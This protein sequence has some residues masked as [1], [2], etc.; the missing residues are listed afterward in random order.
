MGVTELVDLPKWR[1]DEL[2]RAELKLTCLE[3]AG[4]DNWTG[5]EDAMNEFFD[6]LREEEEEEK[7]KDG[8][9]D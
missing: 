5:Y 2:I 8:S 4:V 3:R 6:L 7:A 9:R 1:H